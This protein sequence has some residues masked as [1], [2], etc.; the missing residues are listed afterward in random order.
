MLF[1]EWSAARM[2]MR[3]AVPVFLMLLFSAPSSLPAQ[4]LAQFGGAGAAPDGEGN[5]FMLAGNEAFRTGLS[6]RFNISRMSD[7]GLQIGIDRACDESFFGGGIDFKLVLLESRAELPVNLAL[8]ASFGSLNS[9]ALGRI[10]FGFGILASG[11]IT[12]DSRRAI[13]PYL[14][15]IVDV[16]QLERKHKS[17]RAITC[18]CPGNDDDTVTDTLV[19]TGVKLPVSN[20]AQIIIEAELNG[21]A[22]IGVA[23]NLVF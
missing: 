12:T 6:A 20:E 18:L 8:D 16:E 9:D 17:D 10:L 5:V 23:F 2:N 19:R 7:F 21:R 15:L 22:L 3:R 1:T 11:R 14:S 13:E 4:T